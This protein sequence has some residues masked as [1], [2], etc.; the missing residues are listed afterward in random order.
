MYHEL[1]YL[2][3]PTEQLI[4]H[5]KL[6]DEEAK[7]FWLRS[8]LW[9]KSNPDRTRYQ[10]SDHLAEIKLA[11]LVQLIRDYSDS[12]EFEEIFGKLTLNLE[13]FDRWWF[14]EVYDVEESFDLVEK[15]IPADF[16]NQMQLTGLPIVD[17]WI[18]K[19]R[20]K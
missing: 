17:F 4:E 6:H 16:Y 1:Y 9:Q 2:F 18:K 7:R 12:E 8:I 3:R 13:T 19:H 14:I 5:L 10:Q 20:N 11:F 15:G